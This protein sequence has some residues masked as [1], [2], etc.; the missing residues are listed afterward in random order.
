[1]L[2]SLRFSSIRLVRSEFNLLYTA[3][4]AKFYLRSLLGYG[5]EQFAKVS[6]IEFHKPSM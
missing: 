1:M 6:K 2:A 3:M 4:A 5:S